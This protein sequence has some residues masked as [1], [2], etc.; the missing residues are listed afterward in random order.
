VGDVGYESRLELVGRL[1]FGQG[2]LQLGR[3]GGDRL[4]QVGRVLA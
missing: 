3:P 1:G 2:L 4:L